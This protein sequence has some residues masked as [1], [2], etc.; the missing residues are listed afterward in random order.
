MESCG[1]VYIIQSLKNGRYYIGSTT[2]IERR[3]MEHNLGKSKY[4]SE[5]LP[6]KLV[7]SQNYNNLLMAR[8]IE[9]WLKK[10]K[11]VDF[12]RR[13]IFEGRINKVFG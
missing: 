12:I 4:T 2:D 5:L 7:F 1:W 6:W 9:Y 10:Q 8:K 13:L 11:D 3:L